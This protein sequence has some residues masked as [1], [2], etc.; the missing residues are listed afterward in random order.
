MT[1]T[2]RFA[3]LLGAV[4]A[5]CLGQTITTIAGNGKPGFSGDG[6]PAPQ[7]Q[8]NE[9]RRVPVDRS[10]NLYI[11]DWRNNRVRRVDPAG[12]I[13]TFAGSGEYPRFA[14]DPEVGDGGP[15]ERAKLAEPMAVAVDRDDS[16]YI[17]DSIRVR[18]VGKNG[19]IST[20]AGGGFDSISENIRATDAQ[21]I[22]GLALAVDGSGNIYVSLRS[23]VRKIDGAGVIRTVAGSN[24]RRG[25][26]GD[27]GPAT[28]ATF[29]DITD[30]AADG[31]GDLYLADSKNHRVRK[32]N[33]SGIVTTFA[34]N[35]KA[36]SGGDGGPAS[37]TEAAAHALAI[38]SAGSIY[39]AG[40][41]RI[42][43]VTPG[44]MI[45]TI[46]GGGNQDRDGV[47][48][49]QAYLGDPSGIAVDLGGNVFIA[50]LTG[51]RV[52]RVSA[53][54]SFHP[55]IA[56]NGVV[57]APSYAPT[58]APGTLFSVFGSDLA[59]ATEAAPAVPL[60]ST[61]AGVS[62]TVNGLKAPLVYVSPVQINAQLPYEIEPGTAIVAVTVNGAAG[63]PAPASPLAR[64]RAA[65]TAMV[66]GHN[67][68]VLFAG[69]TPGFVGLL[70]VN[71]RVPSVGNG[72][73]PL[74]ISIG[75]ARSNG[76]RLW[77]AP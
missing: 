37:E 72:S 71:L 54:T 17:L 47:S 43:K 65:V 76:A 34:G 56:A 14:A 58:L 39:L 22:G 32:V 4:T 45:S 50:D 11:A 25:Y 60:P 66:G 18:K 5:I 31:G 1:T 16:V 68:D 55:R 73:Q 20:V 10:G 74:V 9:P 7:A 75:G 15:A 59:P 13:S 6:G 26:A 52:R 40:D 41:N 30:V 53:Q 42:R 8:V 28:E 62:V 24:Q 12:A 21:I 67:A 77:V 36:G 29:Q 19:I 23:R 51:H 48:A 46:A 35:G 70:Q 38:D 44:G 2:Y 57:N 63:A 64:P 33:S 27:G 69:L 3:T 49:R 61:L